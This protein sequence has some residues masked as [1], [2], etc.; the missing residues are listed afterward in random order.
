MTSIHRILLAVKDPDAA[1]QPGILKAIRIA[2]ALGVPLELFHALTTPVSVELQPAKRHTLDDMRRNAVEHAMGRLGKFV[3]VARRRGVSLTCSAAWDYPAHEAVVRR[4]TQQGADL[5]IA[6]Y[7]K[8]ARTRPWLI[9][10]ADWE[11]LRISSIPVLLLRSGA[12]YD[13]PVILAA[14][15]PGHRHA[16]PAALD[17]K[18][19]ER[20]SELSERLHGKLAVMHANHSSLHGLAL[21]D[22]NVNKS[23]LTLTYDDLRRQGRTRFLQL[24]DAAGIDRSQAHFMEGDPT[25]AIPRSARKLRANLVVMGAVSRTGVQ[26]VFI[27]N[28]AERVLNAL[29]CDVLVVKPDGFDAHI[30]T[31]PTGMRLTM[32]PPFAPIPV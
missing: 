8:G 10:L 30:D 17:T 27:G 32:P 2:E 5:I 22:P 3:P 23:S 18:I 20:A 15:D 19:V 28:T 12:P 6:E 9:H 11:L 31:Q 25:V 4:A 21:G 7:H 29:P 16:K 24:V 14:V 1:R 13:R 26:R